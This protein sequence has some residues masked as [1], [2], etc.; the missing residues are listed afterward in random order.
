MTL[1]PLEPYGSFLILLFVLDFLR[2]S[3][4]LLSC[5][6]GVGPELYG[7][8]PTKTTTCKKIK[9]LQ[10]GVKLSEFAF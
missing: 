9:F 1:I 4:I 2:A 6:S 7:L 3:P 5:R 8:N 10:A